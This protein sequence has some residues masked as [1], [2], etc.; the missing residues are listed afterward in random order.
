LNFLS[1]W[2]NVRKWGAM[3]FQV[4]EVEIQ[5]QIDHSCQKYS[6][7]QCF[8]VTFPIYLRLGI[9]NHRGKLRG[10]NS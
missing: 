2:T 8:V 9:V 7:F 10:F 4:D 6:S 1:L 3:E 5:I